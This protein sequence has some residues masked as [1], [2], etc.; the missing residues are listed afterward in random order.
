[1]KIRLH[2]FLSKS[3]IF[4]SKAK[5]KEAICEDTAAILIEP[6]QGEGGVIEAP[7]EFI[8]ELN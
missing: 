7:L 3:G 1:M 8:K 4:T 2:Q 5:V 6:I